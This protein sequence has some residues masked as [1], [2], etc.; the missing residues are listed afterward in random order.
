M[1]NE[2][3]RSQIIGVGQDYHAWASSNPAH[4]K[5]LTEVH[6]SDYQFLM[7]GF[8][9][10]HIH[11]P[12]F[13]QLGLGLDMPLLDWLNTY[14]FPLE[15]K[16]SNHQYAQQVYQGVVVSSTWEHTNVLSMGRTGR[17]F[18]L[19][20][21]DN[22]TPQEATLRCGTTL[23]SYFATNHLESTLTLA[24]EAVRQGQRAL[25]GKVC[26]NCNSPEFY[27]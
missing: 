26:S 23:A 21:N 1:S 6:L 15:A 25:I 14:T 18:L 13:A 8:V 9:D 10:C 19:A 22:I 7:P 17:L 12:Q 11:A 2:Q 27:V 16:F 4:A 24:R 5:G 3:F 20:D